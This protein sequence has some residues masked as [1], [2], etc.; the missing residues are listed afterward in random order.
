MLKSTLRILTL[1]LIPTLAMSDERLV[2]SLSCDDG[3]AGSGVIVSADGVILTAKHVIGK[4]RSCDVF[5]NGGKSVPARPSA[6]AFVADGATLKMEG[7]ET[8]FYAKFCP[9]DGFR[10]QEVRAFGFHDGSKSTPSETDGV[11][12]NTEAKSGVI[13]MTAMAI[14]GKSGGPVFLKNT[15]VLVGIIGGAEF[16]ATGLVKYYGMVPAEDLAGLGLTREP[17]CEPIKP[18]SEFPLQCDL[19]A[20]VFEG[21]ASDIANALNNRGVALSRDDKWRQARECFVAALDYE[22]NW[23]RYLENA[24]IAYWEYTE[25][26]ERMRAFHYVD[27]QIG[28]S[29]REISRIS[30]AKINRFKGRDC[31]WRSNFT[32]EKVS[33]YPWQQKA[34]M[35]SSLGRLD[36]AIDVLDEAVEAYPK[37]SCHYANKL[38][39]LSFTR[40][41]V[42]CDAS[43][44]GE[45]ER[46]Y[47]DVALNGGAVEMQEALIEQKFLRGRADGIFGR[48]SKAALKSWIEAGCPG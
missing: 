40:G 13:E 19:P 28:I 34:F 32:G 25:G 4:S 16:S 44:L 8:P 24:R 1:S 43:R 17:E 11:L 29:T 22:P 47:L 27:R 15:K 10:G 5:M 18:G 35:L 14:E 33:T 20:S 45:A 12:A 36:E 2:V 46:I 38:R 9:V 6:A 48:K 30:I 26:D 23:P 37:V 31:E 42:F 7:T 21:N 39:S 3:S 41:A